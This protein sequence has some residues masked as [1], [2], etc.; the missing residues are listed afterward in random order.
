MSLRQQIIIEELH[1]AASDAFDEFKH[2]S[3]KKAK[4]PNYQQMFN[5]M[6]SPYFSRTF[7]KLQRAVTRAEA[8]LKDPDPEPPVDIPY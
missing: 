7:V 3:T 6:S 1:E 8:Y 2:L 4:S 5:S